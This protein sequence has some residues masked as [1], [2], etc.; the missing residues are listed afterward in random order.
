MGAEVEALCGAGY[1]E[2]SGERVNRGTAI[3]PGTSTPGWARSNSPS[4]NSAS[5]ATSPTGCSSPVGGPSGPSPRWWPS[6]TSRGVSTRRVEGL[7]KTLGIE[8]LSKSQVLGMAKTSTQRSRPSEPAPRPGPLHLRLARRHGQKV[9]EDGR[10]RQR[11]RG[12]RHRRQR[13]GHREVLGM[14][15]ITTEDGAGWLAFLRGL[16]ARGLS[17]MPLV[18][19]DAHPGLVDADRS[20][21]GSTW[22]RCRTHFM[23][24]LLTRSRNRPGVG[25]H[26]GAHDL[27]PARPRARS[28]PSTPGS[29]SSWPES[30]PTPPTSSP[31]PARPAAFTA[32]PKE[33]WK[34]IWSNN[35]QERL[36]KSSA[37]AP[38]SS[39]S[40]PRARSGCSLSVVH[41][42][43]E[44]RQ[45]P[46]KLATDSEAWECRMRSS[47]LMNLIGSGRGPRLSKHS[48]R[49][50]VAT[51]MRFGQRISIWGY[52]ISC[53]VAL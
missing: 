20:T 45:L 4:L 13:R 41:R 37:E 36:N 24:N 42:D 50:L 1:G 48:L 5:A 43:L 15:V 23:R 3:G 8:R 29:S 10:I 51:C 35:P 16:V 9:R 22:Q 26:L 32:F 53:Y 31:R 25:G 2:V 7:V 14:D 27:R 47:T 28:R 6:A 30:S 11:G 40:R 39:A 21:L 18:V 38:T 33:H 49:L 34:Q 52:A 17:G 46:G 12:H 44:S 19:S